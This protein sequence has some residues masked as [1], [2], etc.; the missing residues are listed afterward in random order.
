MIISPNSPYD[1]SG[2]VKLSH[3]KATKVSKIC[4]DIESLI[5]N[6]ERSLLQ[7][8]LSLNIYRNKF[9]WNNDRLV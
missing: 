2:T 4:D 9:K 8:L 7:V 1:K 5:S 3:A 6:S